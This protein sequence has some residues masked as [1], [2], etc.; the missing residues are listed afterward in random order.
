MKMNALF[1]VLVVAAGGCKPQMGDQPKYRAYQE[2]DFFADGAAM[3]P[4]PPHTV[5]RGQ[6]D[7]DDPYRTGLKD[8]LLVAQLPEPLTPQLLAR[9]QERFNVYCSVCHGLTGAGD[10]MIVQRGFPAPDSFHSPRL[11]AAPVGYFVRVMTEGYGAMYPYASRVAPK[12]RW[13]IAAYIRA[14]QLSQNASLGD[15]PPETRTQLENTP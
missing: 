11:R 12:D 10:G 13:A 8:G 14:L 6:F 4:V 5:A 3:R 7:A 15:L 2:N 1:F 9:G